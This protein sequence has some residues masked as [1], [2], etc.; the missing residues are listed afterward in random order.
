MIAPR[1]LNGG[2]K[3][4]ILLLVLLTHPHAIAAESKNPNFTHFHLSPFVIQWDGNL[5]LPD[6]K[7]WHQHNPQHFIWEAVSHH[8]FIE[9]S[10]GVTH[11][12]ENQGSFRISDTQKYK[13]DIQKINS[14]H[15]VQDELVIQGEFRSSDLKAS[16]CNF[17]YRFRFHPITHQRLGFEFELL[18]TNIESENVRSY[19]NYKSAVDEDFYGFGEQFTHFGL[20]GLNVPIL[21]Q[22]Q[23]IGRGLEPLSSIINKISPGSSGS[24]SSTYAPVPH[25][26]SSKMRSLFLKNTS[27]SE[28]DFRKEDEVTIKT[29]HSKMSGEILYGNNPL[30]LIET[31]TEFS[32]RMKPLPD[33]AHEGVVIAVQGGNEVV[34]KVQKQVEDA[35]IPVS[36]FWIQDWV[37]RYKNKFGSFLWWN[38][39]VDRNLYPNWEEMVANLKEKGIRTL[40]YF[41]PFV[42]KL[43]NS[44]NSVQNKYEEVLE[45]GLSIFRKDGTPYFSKF[46]FFDVLLLDLTRFQAREWI[47]NIMKWQLMQT[48]ISGW[49]A[50]FGES[51]PMDAKL[52]DSSLDSF[53]FHNQYP[54]EWAKIQNEVISETH[55][56]N[57][58]LTFVRSGY[59]QSPGYA[60]LFWLGD[61]LTSWDH[62]DGMKTAL[63]GLL[64]SGLSGYSLNHSDTGGYTSVTQLVI[65]IYRTK[66]LFMRW[67]ELNAFTPFFRT[68]EG[69]Q[70]E[71]NC[72]FNTDD[73]TLTHFTRF[74]K[75]FRALAPYRKELMQEAFK[76]GYPLVRAL[77]L[78]FPRDPNVF[79]IDDEF[80]LGSDFLVAPIL[81]PHVHVRKVYLPEGNWNSVFSQEK[82]SVGPSGAWVHVLAPIGKPPVFYKQESAVAHEFIQRLYE[83]KVL[84]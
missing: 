46:L 48:G 44:S 63:T 54:V 57:E 10:I 43:N 51:L 4:I 84:K 76:K 72:Q 19:L 29:Y 73:E 12:F 30:E 69:N 52:F 20:K 65:D 32:G 28:F 11:V 9:A 80:L 3:M 35:G 75:I 33:W 53:Q 36:A 59:S 81:N 39:V 17:S 70:P 14:I 34:R 31:Y 60:Q 49:M 16:Q 66:E 18:N 45:Q 27:Y 58:V 38:W 5:K 61:Q 1:V 82:W 2:V 22:E 62:F 13:C 40:T 25:Y 74:A 15:Q 64:S 26:I 50:D 24:W 8:P 47:K 71:K 77:F 41:N 21:V 55:L 7:I 68:H 6:F 83:E 23:G 56:E 78:H 42:A 37:G 79:P 67:A